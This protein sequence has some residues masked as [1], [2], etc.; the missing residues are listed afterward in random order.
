MK[1]G[2]F[3]DEKNRRVGGK[4]TSEEYWD[5]YYSKISGRGAQVFG[6]GWKERLATSRTQRILSRLY[7]GFLPK[8]GRVLEIGSAPGRTLIEMSRKLGAEPYGIEYSRIGVEIQRKLFEREGFDP[9]NVIEADL[10]SDEIASRWNRYFDVVASFGFIEHFRNPREVVARHI[11]LVKPNGRIVVTIPNLQGFN[12]VLAEVFNRGILVRHNTSIMDRETFRDLFRGQNVEELFCD[13][14]G[15]FSPAISSGGG[16]ISAAG[17]LFLVAL[18]KLANM[19]L[20]F[21]PVDWRLEHKRISPSL[22]FIGKCR[23]EY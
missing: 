18:Q 15:T 20:S 1:M 13:F 3:M 4:L 12:L 9:S 2:G 14:V 17:R 21:F 11:E 7:D 16:H 6:N 19:V 10:F 22:V 5:N 23:G 8:N